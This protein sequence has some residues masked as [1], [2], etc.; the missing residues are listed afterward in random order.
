MAL[1]G[2]PRIAQIQEIV[3]TAFDLPLTSMR[4]RQRSRKIA[5]PRQIA[6][7][8]AGELTRASLPV[9]GRAFGNRDHT[10]VM[11]AKK[12]IVE[13]MTMDIEFATLVE[14]LRQRA[15]VH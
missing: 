3:A 11:H 7:Y 10:T 8:L 2:G 15:S 5:R 9:I 6:M 13:M 12:T 14:T 1:A 4:S